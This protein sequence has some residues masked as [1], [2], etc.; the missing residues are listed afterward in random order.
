MII[1]FTPSPEGNRP[2]WQGLR[3]ENFMGIKHL[4]K[5]IVTRIA[6][7]LIIFVILCIIITPFYF[8]S[9]QQV[10]LALLSTAIIVSFLSTRT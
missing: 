10:I 5:E 8:L 9:Q 4:L 1:V 6:H 2:L 3:K 7:I